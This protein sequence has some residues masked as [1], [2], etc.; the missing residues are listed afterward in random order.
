MTPFIP[1]WSPKPPEVLR[2]Y[3]EDV[4][5]DYRHNKPIRVRIVVDGAPYAL[6]TGQTFNGFEFDSP[7]EQLRL[8]R[9][10]LYRDGIVAEIIE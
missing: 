5:S 2:A 6:T 9:P 8:T 4:Q 1:G 7:E 10:D 3:I